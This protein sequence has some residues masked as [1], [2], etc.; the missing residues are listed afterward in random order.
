MIVLLFFVFFLFFYKSNLGNNDDY[1]SLKQTTAINGIFIIF[2]FFRHLSQYI[3]FN[4][5]LDKPMILIDKCSGQLIV[6]MF[7]FNSGFGILES[8][9]NK[10]N[11][12]DTIP[13]KRIL[14]T[15]IRFDICVCFYYL[16]NLT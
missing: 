11:Y 4:N 9:K 14:K 15:L 3:T 6:T 13:R 12:I 1:L 2:V 8:I 16:I 10:K 7:L 5:I